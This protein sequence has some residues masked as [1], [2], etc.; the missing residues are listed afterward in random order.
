M[1]CI[2][3]WLPIENALFTAY[4]QR[5]ITPIYTPNDEYLVVMQLKEQ[6]Q[7]DPTALAL[8]YIRSSTGSLVPLNAVANIST[9]VGPLSVNHQGQ[10]PALTISFNLAT[11]AAIGD[12]VDEI[13]EVARKE[14]P[15]T[16]STQ[17]QGTAQAFQSSVTGLG[18]LLL[19]AILVIYLVLGVLYERFIR[20]LTILSGL[21][22]AAPGALLTFQIFGCGPDLYGF[23]GIVMLIGIVKKNAIMMVDF[24]VQLERDG[25]KTAAEAIYES[26]LVRFRPIIMTT[27][28]ALRGTAPIAFGLGSGANSR[29]SLGLAVV[30]GLIFSQL[31]TLYLTPVFYTYVDSFQ[32]WLE[33]LFGMILGERVPTLA[34]GS[35]SAD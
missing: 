11:G 8:L 27:M 6:Y 23:V 19:I 9:G 32:S 4:G 22:S 34:E 14:L 15:A 26:C 13:A 33:R 24:A 30:G 1:Q 21:P 29:R 2:I 10:L 7:H 17:F 28:A 12:A 31:V 35:T 3:H 16:V 20:P 5:Q 18:V 25:L